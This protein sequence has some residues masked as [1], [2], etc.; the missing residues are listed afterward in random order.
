MNWPTQSPMKGS[1][2]LRLRVTTRIYLSRASPWIHLVS[3]DSALSD[4]EQGTRAMTQRPHRKNAALINSASEL[5]FLLGVVFRP[6]LTTAE[7][8]NVKQQH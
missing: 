7:S 3:R 2:N 4:Q 1:V 8:D 6:H 5:A